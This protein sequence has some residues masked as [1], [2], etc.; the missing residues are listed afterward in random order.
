M[1]SICMERFGFIGGLAIALA[2]L[3]NPSFTDLMFHPLGKD[4]FAHTGNNF[5]DAIV[6]QPFQWAIRFSEL[7]AHFHLFP[8]G[9]ECLS[10]MPLAKTVCRS[11]I[12]A[13]TASAMWMVN[14]FTLFELMC[15][16]LT[17]AFLWFMPLAIWQFM[18]VSQ[19][20]NQVGWPRWRAPVLAGI[21]TAL[22]GW[23][24][25]FAG[26]FLGLSLM[27]LAFVECVKMVK[28]RRLDSKLILG[29]LVAGASCLT[30]IAP[31]AWM[32]AGLESDGL[33]PGMDNQ[34]SSIFQAPAPGL[35][36]NVSG[37]HGYFHMELLGRPML[38]Y[39][40]W[41]GAIIA[42]LIW[43]RK[44]RVWLDYVGRLVAVFYW[45]ADPPDLYVSLYDSGAHGC[46]RRHGR[47]Y[48]FRPRFY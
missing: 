2:N 35:R 33:V 27:V 11:R 22:Q 14:P 6:A 25:W 34:A 41:G 38:A 44:A 46:W 7:P 24:Y 9:R 8:F 30:L 19:S 32:M 42:L 20:A 48:W 37:V 21:F 36:N 15:G 13:W 28:Q 1:E 26:Y 45:V 12:G 47:H 18:K 3:R 16:R 17:Q 43:G 10:F 23:T 31:A 40:V 29:W 4:I 39:W 5:I